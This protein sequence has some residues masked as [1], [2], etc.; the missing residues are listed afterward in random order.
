[1][2]NNCIHKL[3]CAKYTATGGHVNKCEH[4]K[5]ERLQECL[6]CEQG[7]E[8]C[9]TCKKFFDYYGDGGDR[10]SACFDDEKCTFYE[11]IGYCPRCGRDMRGA[12]DG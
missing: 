2:C 8:L 4:F 6:W 5:E 12:E 1:M 10:C 9:G 7:N 3:V 11:P